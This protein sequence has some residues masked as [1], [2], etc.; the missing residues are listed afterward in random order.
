MRKLVIASLCV[1]L[2]ATTAGCGI[3]RQIRHGINCYKTAHYAGAMETWEEVGDCHC[4][5]N[6]KATVR[7]LVYRGLTHYHLGEHRRAYHF[8]R[9]GQQVYLQGSPRWLPLGAVVE[10]N[11]ILA[12]TPP[13]RVGSRIVNID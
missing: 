1:L 4:Q 9:K 8:L 13:P 7:Y 11:A 3:G 5:L 2:F 10:M 12:R 6:H